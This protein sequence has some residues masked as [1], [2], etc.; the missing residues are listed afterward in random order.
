[1]Q[2]LVLFLRAHRL[3]VALT[4]VFVALAAFMVWSVFGPRSDWRLEAIRKSGYPLTVADLETW[5][6]QVPDSDNAALICAQ[7]FAQPGF[8]NILDWEENSL[9]QDWFP[10]RGHVLNEET[11]GEVKS[12]LATHNLALALL[13]STQTRRRSHYPVRWNQGLDIP[14]P[15]LPQV[16]AAVIL[17]RAEALLHCADGDNEKAVQA[18]LAAGHVADSLASEPS[19]SSHLSR[20]SFWAMTVAGMERVINALPLTEDQLP[21]L[22][23]MVREAENPQAL[24]RALGSERAIGL[25]LFSEPTARTTLFSGRRFEAGVFFGLRRVAGIQERDKAFYLDVMATNI[26]IAQMSWPDRVELAR[27]QAGIYPARIH[28]FFTLSAITLPGLDKSFV[29]DADHAARLRTVQAALALQRFRLAHGNTLPASLRELEP[30]WLNRIPTDPYDGQALRYKKRG[31]G[32]VIYSI[33]SD[34][35]DDEGLAK[36]S[37]KPGR[38]YDIPFIVEH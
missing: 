37:T 10:P 13:H 6:P 34:G 4:A 29:R 27:Q 33:G 38:S 8:S 12:L 23:V 36:E 7:A 25:S 5:Y 30:T 18:L 24:A 35:R 32:F 20:M 2:R 14:L 31:S 21:S 3:R 26:A 19:L 9:P 28:R 11:R 15:H 1:V 16:K 22:Q 17:L